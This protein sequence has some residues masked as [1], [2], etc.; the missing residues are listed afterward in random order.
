MEEHVNDRKPRETV[1]VVGICGSLRPD[2]YTH[3]AVEIAL[4]GARERGAETQLIDLKAYDLVFCDGSKTEHERAPGVAQLR[5]EVHQAQ[6]II[7]GTPEYHGSYS[8]VL[9]NALDL[10]GFDE[11]GGKIVGMIGVSGGAMGAANALNSL[12]LVGRSLHAWV[13]PL[14]VSVP[15]GWKQFDNQGQL[16]DAV[17]QD[18]LKE[19]GRQVARFSYLHNS[20]HAQ[21]FLNMWEE[22]P[23]NPG[24]D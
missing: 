18:R 9:K 7:L 21:E 19:V 4:Q 13:I 15:Q 8:G 17:L 22:S 24:A 11:F 23:S 6:G 3:R 20:Q 2:G 12:R 10:M 16:K 5:Q 14:Q 1:H